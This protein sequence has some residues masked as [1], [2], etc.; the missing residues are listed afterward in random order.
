MP[1]PLAGL[2]PIFTLDGVTPKV[3]PDAF[4]APLRR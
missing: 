2:G 3:A 1:E 4:I